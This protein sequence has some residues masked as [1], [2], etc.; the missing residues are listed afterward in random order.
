MVK[1]ICLDVG[2]VICNVNLQKFHTAISCAFNISELEAKNRMD[3]YQRMNDI[4]LVSMSQI[5]RKEFDIFSE[6]R[7]KSLL[8]MWNDTISINHIV[9]DRFNKLSSEYDLRIALL[10]NMGTDHAT[11]IKNM[12][13]SDYLFKTTTN[14]FSCDIGCR[15]PQKLFYKT[16]VDLNPQFLGSLYVDDLD[17]NLS[18][19]KDFFK[20][21]KFSLEEPNVKQEL[22]KI[23]RLLEE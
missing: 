4:G 23:E 20:P 3:F 6:E 22:D 16:F 21:F 14:I 8:D 1:Y 18:A 19:A 9:I 15:K 17:E 10:S 12:L 7:V 11:I 13:K 5:L 2:N